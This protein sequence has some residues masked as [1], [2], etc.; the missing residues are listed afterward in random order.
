M[1]RHEDPAPTRSQPRLL[2][3]VRDVIRRLH[4]SIRTEQT[5]VDWIRRFILFHGKRH[6][7]DMGVPEGET[8]L[9]RLAVQGKRWPPCTQNQALNAIV[10]LYRQV[11]KKGLRLTQGCNACQEAGQA[12]GRV[13][14]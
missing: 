2:D 12:T 5:Y 6:P 1:D 10:F 3:Q 7:E 13:H 8:F 14:G 11:L 9:T 4:Y